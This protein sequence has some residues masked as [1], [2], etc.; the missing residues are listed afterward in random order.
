MLGIF[1]RSLSLLWRLELT[2]V[3]LFIQCD[4]FSFCAKFFYKLRSG[5]SSAHINMVEKLMGFDSTS[6]EMTLML[7]TLHMGTMFALIA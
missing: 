3:H 5:S 6:L 7:V 1:R 2:Y 4:G